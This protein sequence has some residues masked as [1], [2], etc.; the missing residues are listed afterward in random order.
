M[1]EKTNCKNT[2][3]LKIAVDFDN[4]ITINSYGDKNRPSPFKEGIVPFLNSLVD[5]GHF[6]YLY[7]S[8]RGKELEQVKKRIK[9]AGLKLDLEY[10]YQTLGK[11]DYDILLDDRA[12]DINTFIGLW[13]DLWN[14]K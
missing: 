14:L 11:P 13:R 5:Q 8:R 6:L 1:V 9:R 10:A 7:T 12:I 4:T 2:V 3:K